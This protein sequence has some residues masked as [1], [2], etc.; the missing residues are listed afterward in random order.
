MRGQ[1]EGSGNVRGGLRSYVLASEPDGPGV[2]TPRLSLCEGVS[3]GPRQ[4]WVVRAPNRKCLLHGPVGSDIK[5]AK[6]LCLPVG[7]R[8]QPLI[9]AKWER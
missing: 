4:R 7:Y 1:D 3:S 9:G 2:V 8:P 6:A 5:R